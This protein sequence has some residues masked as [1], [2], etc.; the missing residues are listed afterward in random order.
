MMPPA[1]STPTVFVVDDDKLMR[2]SL[3]S[4][5]QAL[6]HQVLTFCSAAQFR[7]YYRSSM[8]G[9]LLLDVHMPRQNGLELYEQLLEQ[10]IRLPA[11]FVTA[12]ADVSTAVAAMKTGAIE[13]LEKP[14]ERATL[15]TLLDKALALDTQWRQQ[16][17]ELDQLDAKID[18]LT[19]R[20]RETLQ[21]IIDGCSN[22]L[23]AARLDLTERAIEMRRASI[24]RKLEVESVAELLN[25]AVTHR[26]M[27][28][29][30]RLRN[31]NGFA[32]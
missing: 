30:R 24:M 1:P 16:E 31:Q 7:Y 13:F 22:K 6:G 5:I 29:V 18:S 17:A 27:N 15:E 25:V 10:G 9:C 2:D 28:D 11:I 4:L 26:V 19:S 20:E 21:M 3:E 14:F 8:P 23:M 12:H 32:R